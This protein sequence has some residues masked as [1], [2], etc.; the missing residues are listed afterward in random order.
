MHDL[1]VPP[2]RKPS[3]L[4]R[5]WNKLGNGQSNPI[6]QDRFLPFRS[7][8][9][10]SSAACVRVWPAFWKTLKD[11]QKDFQVTCFKYLQISRN[12]GECD[13]QQASMEDIAYDLVLLMD[14]NGMMT[15]SKMIPGWVVDT[16]ERGSFLTAS[17]QHWLRLASL[18]CCENPIWYA[19]QGTSI[20]LNW[21]IF[22]VDTY[23]IWDPN[24]NGIPVLATLV[25]EFMSERL[26]DRDSTIQIN[27]IVPRCPLPFLSLLC[28]RRPE[29]E[30]CFAR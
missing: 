15:W 18:A 27:G 12:T 2:F 13:Q 21:C 8:L 7:S 1:G 19:Q 4:P 28:I 14:L 10:A 5:S 24:C 29:V 6:D 11:F 23:E 3:N 30:C 26:K 20:I 16:K 17:C 22:H 9:T 25:W